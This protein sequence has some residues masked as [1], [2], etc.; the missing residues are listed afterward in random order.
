M[1]KK[2]TTA[3]IIEDIA[4]IIVRKKRGT[5]VKGALG[6]IKPRTARGELKREFKR[7]FP[8]ASAVGFGGLAIYGL[9]QLSKSIR[10]TEKAPDYQVQ[11]L[12]W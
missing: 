10:I 2:P 11:R 3:G 12:K 8:I 9:Y 7:I 4:D 5:Y 1:A 6:G